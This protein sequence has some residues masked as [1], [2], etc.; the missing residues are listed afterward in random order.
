M[1]LVGTIN[2][3]FQM[4]QGFTTLVFLEC[5]Q[6]EPLCLSTAVQQTQVA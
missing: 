3:G 1:A 5:Q 2:Q 6:T 4:M